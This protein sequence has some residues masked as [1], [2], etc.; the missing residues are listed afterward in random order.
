MPPRK[1]DR[2]MVHVAAGSNPKLADLTDSEYRAHISG[3]LAV[4]AMSPIRGCLLVGEL[5]AEPKHVAKAAGVSDRAARSA[6]TKLK[7]LGVL[8]EDPE[9]GC[10]RVH[11]WEQLNPEP[12]KDETATERQK[13]LREKRR[14]AMRNGGV[15][16]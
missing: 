1:F 12:R 15:T 8:Y 10:L 16:V 2:Y 11:D 6:M 7:A 5:N 9:L 3:V 13:R 14:H 4:A